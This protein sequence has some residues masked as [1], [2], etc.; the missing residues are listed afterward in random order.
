MRGG[1]QPQWD[2]GLSGDAVRKGPSQ[3]PPVGHAFGS[4]PGSQ[5][6]ACEGANQAGQK[7][8]KVR[9]NLSRPN[10][11]T[12]QGRT[13]LWTSE[14]TRMIKNWRPT[15]QPCRARPHGACGSGGAGYLHGKEDG[16]ARPLP[17]WACLDGPRTQTCG[18]QTR[19]H[20]ERA[21]VMGE[22]PCPNRTDPRRLVPNKRLPQVWKDIRNRNID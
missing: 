12:T 4:I 20:T 17:R 15:T 5:T 1:W 21:S 16:L 3:D 11:N 2:F 10:P 18:A 9:P 7:K 19:P 22:K 14:I 6:K 13:L 8:T